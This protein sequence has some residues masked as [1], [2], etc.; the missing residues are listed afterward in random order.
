[1]RC[2]SNFNRISSFVYL[3]N[4][5]RQVSGQH[6]NC[7]GGFLGGPEVF[8]NLLRVG[9]KSNEK[10]HVGSQIRLPLAICGNCRTCS[11]GIKNLDFRSPGD[12]L[13]A[14]YQKFRTGNFTY[15]KPGDKNVLNN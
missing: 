11:Y 4:R 8:L 10:F 9:I 3:G 14:T 2:H 5:G 12:A 7:L 15:L 1:M 6:E 13:K